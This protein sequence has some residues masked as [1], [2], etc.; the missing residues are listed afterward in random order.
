MSLSDYGT[1]VV[2]TVTPF[3]V[4]WVVALAAKWGLDLDA[5]TVTP[6][7][8]SVIGVVYYAVVRKVEEKH[9]EAGKLLGK[10]IAPNYSNGGE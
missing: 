7:A 10:A 6:I 2:R 9:P 8:A 5:A 1:S 3:I 4:G